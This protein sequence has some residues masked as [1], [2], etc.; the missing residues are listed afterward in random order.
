MP[1]PARFRVRLVSGPMVVTA[2][3][4]RDR[5]A[6]SRCPRPT[7]P[8][9][10][11]TE[12]RVRGER[13]HPRGR[14]TTGV[15][16]SRPGRAERRSPGKAQCSRWVPA[17]GTTSLGVRRERRDRGDHRRGGRGRHPESRPSRRRW[18]RG[19]AGRV[20]EAVAL[21]A[22]HLDGA[23]HEVVPRRDGGPWELGW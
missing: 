2:P 12:R 6:P 21:G 19:Q 18:P 11:Q 7:L 8:A 17:V 3:S 20:A 15:T 4:S 23:V 22:L 1:R 13:P 9:C 5:G 14:A 10:G 16:I